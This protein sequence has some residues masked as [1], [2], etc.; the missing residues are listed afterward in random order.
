MGSSGRAFLPE[1][2]GPCQNNTKRALSAHCN[3][4]RKMR[5]TAIKSL[6]TPRLF[7]NAI[8]RARRLAVR[9]GRSL[10]VGSECCTASDA[11]TNPV[12]R[13]RDTEQEIEPARKC[14]KK[15]DRIPKL[16]NQIKDTAVV[17]ASTATDESTANGLFMLPPPEITAT[18]TSNTQQLTTDMRP[19][20]FLQSPQGAMIPNTINC[21]HGLN[22]PRDNLLSL[23]IAAMPLPL[24]IAQQHETGG[25]LSASF[26]QS[27]MWASA[28]CRPPSM[29]ADLQTRPSAMAQAPLCGGLAA[30]LAWSHLI[31]RPSLCGPGF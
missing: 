20:S 16:D 18:N 1:F 26:L 14:L 24:G 23:L 15:T 30:A 13:S 9:T 29:L 5:E 25:L 3:K 31:S 21:H 17:S 6:H 10:S 4:S 7:A 22:S 12:K 27:A 8:R 2:S 11:A 19:D 28:T